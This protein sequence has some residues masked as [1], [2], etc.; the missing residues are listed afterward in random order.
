MR[1]VRV[2]KRFLK[3]K[4]LLIREAIIFR[5]NTNFQTKELKF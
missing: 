5:I 4:A 2:L 1:I 3:I